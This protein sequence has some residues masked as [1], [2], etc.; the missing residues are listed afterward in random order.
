MYYFLKKT[1]PT[2]KDIY[3]QI[4]VSYYDAATKSKK[5]KCHQSL[6]YV[7]RLK[8]D[9]VKD[10]TEFYQKI[11]NELNKKEKENKELKISDKS[12][13]K[14]LG[15]FL[16]K[17]MFDL[18]NMDKDLNF[19]GSSYKCH[20]KFSDLFR[21]LCY[22]Q[23]LSPGSKLKF[24]ENVIPNIYNA[25][26]YSYDQI[27]DYVN[28][29]GSD[30]HKYIE[31]LN[32]HINDNWKR[33][34]DTGYFDC[35]N[36]YFE[37]DLENDTLKKGPS[38]ENKRCPLLGQALLLDA[39]QI[40]LDTE[41]YP[42]NE[43]EKQYLRKRIEDIKNKNN[44]KG[45]I[46][47]VADKGLN[48]ARNIYAAVVEANDGYIF[49]KSIKTAGKDVKNW[50]I[51]PDDELNVWI[52]VKDKS[53]KLIYKYKVFKSMTTKGKVVDYGIFKY[54]C[55]LNEDDEK[56]IEFEVKEKRILTY[57][58]SLAAKKK[59]EIL[60]QVSNISNTISYKEALKEELGDGAKYVNFKAVDKE[61][62]QVKIAT[63]INQDKVDEDLKLAGYNLIVT[64]E[65]KA[66]PE[67]IYKT[68]HN[69]WRIENSFRVLKT[70]LE[71]RPAY[72]QLRET[73]YGHFLIC[74]ISLTLLRLLEFKIFNDEIAIDSIIDF[75]RDYKI[76][77][78]FD[79]SYINNATYSGTYEAINKKLELSKLG[80]VY[81]SK[82]DVDNILNV[83]FDI[84]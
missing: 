21:T 58:P 61:G 25:N 18:L 59:K 56:E 38:K 67:Q 84:S 66:S 41:F 76:T 71:A 28:F 45:R 83:E 39:D 78:N 47:Q 36:Y 17:G 15:H 9:E 37:I 7:E 23:I 72:A 77:E 33:N 52:D 32:K 16:I 73:I 60:K 4:Y 22:A 44:I 43:S 3:L 70:Y 69:L 64:S 19:V 13:S 65:L 81:L 11:V 29:L 42:G 57:N 54:H 48:C 1:K 79:G 26:T 6:G 75:I 74:Y 27:L 68:Y 12:T 62:K 35:T 20:Y 30:Y 24:F 8:T 31:V 40:P 55:K 14:F 49:S 50:V 80:N 2:K 46:I 82:K 10:P 34:L 53:G 63:S 5:Q 51:K